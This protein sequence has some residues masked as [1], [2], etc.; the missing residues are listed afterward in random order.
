MQGVSVADKMKGCSKS[1]KEQARE[2]VKR[3]QTGASKVD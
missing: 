1:N 2:D 3:A